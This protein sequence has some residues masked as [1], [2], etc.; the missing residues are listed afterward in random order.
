M[1]FGGEGGRGG[2]VKLRP[3]ATPLLTTVQL[4][5][6]V[7]DQEKKRL[8]EAVDITTVIDQLKKIYGR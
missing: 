8:E 2:G 7:L 4:L 3:G 6:Q 5:N 1:K